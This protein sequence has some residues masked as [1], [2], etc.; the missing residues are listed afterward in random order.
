MPIRLTSEGH[1]A[2]LHAAAPLA[3]DLDAARTAG[4][5]VAF[6]RFAVIFGL[7]RGSLRGHS[8]TNSKSGSASRMR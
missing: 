5:V 1:D 7:R 8:C 4:C 6:A 3:P 2:V